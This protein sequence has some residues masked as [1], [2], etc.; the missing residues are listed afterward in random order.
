MQPLHAIVQR[1]AIYQ[2]MFFFVRGVATCKK[3]DEWGVVQEAIRSFCT[4]F[5]PE[6]P[7]M[8]ETLRNQYYRMLNDF[9][10]EKEV[11]K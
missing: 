7:D 2:S 4:Q 1:N 3:E 11:F 10:G 9:L 6:A 8:E 5:L